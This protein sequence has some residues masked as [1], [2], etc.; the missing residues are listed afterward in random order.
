MGRVTM[1]H[2]A[3]CQLTACMQRGC[4]VRSAPWPAP[5]P[6]DLLPL[7][8]ASPRQAKPQSCAALRKPGASPSR[9]SASRSR[10]R[11]HAS[12][13]S[14]SRAGAAGG[15]VHDER[16]VREGPAGTEVSHPMYEHRA[17]GMVLCMLYPST[18]NRVL[19]QPCACVPVHALMFVP[20]ST[21]S[22]AC[23]E[24]CSLKKKQASHA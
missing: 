8:P 13:V 21:V 7:F 5:H 19:G 12:D 16:D 24:P 18:M 11:S 9:V 2:L 23:L 3:G 17:N 10:A 14:N 1:T 15:A 6:S 20:S 22:L 4:L